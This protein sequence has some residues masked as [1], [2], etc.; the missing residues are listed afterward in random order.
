M[1][2]YFLTN[3]RRYFTACNKNKPVLVQITC[4]FSLHLMQPTDSLRSR[5]CK[6]KR[7]CNYKVLPTDKDYMNDCT[8]ATEKP[9]NSELGQ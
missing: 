8:T 9:T 2:T 1:S 4:T 7:K 6:C 3:P 5:H